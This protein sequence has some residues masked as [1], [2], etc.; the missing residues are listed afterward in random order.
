MRRFTRLFLVTC[1]MLLCSQT[2]WADFKNFSVQVN[3]Q[4]GTL[5]TAAEQTQGT[6]FSFGVAVATDGTV[7]RVETTDASSVA[8]V[9]GKFHSDH[10]ATELSVVVPVDGN[11]KISVGQ[12]TFSGSDIKVTNASGQ[13]V[14]SKSPGKN[15]WK[16]SHDNITELNYTGGATT[17]TISGMGYCPYV[18]VEKSTAVIQKFNV[19]FTNNDSEAVG[20]AP[21]AVAFT[22]GDAP[23]TI[24]ANKT[25]YKEGFTLTAWTDGASKY[26]PGTGFT[27]TADIT[28]TP[29]FEKNEKTLADRTEPVTLLWDFQRKNGAPLLAEEGAGKTGPYVTQ[30]IIDGKSIDVK[31]DYDATNGKIANGNWNDWAQMINGTKF[32][33]PSC[34][35]AVV[36]IEAYSTPTTTTIDGLTD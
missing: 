29:C 7:S 20:K 24:P 9:S 15:C 32:T 26:A 11:V 10:G 17:L 19:T 14:A 1:L 4:A 21:D 8:T 2:S 13:V 25:L 35:G 22:K 23:I 16:N 6:Q 36:S 34:K 12:C 3:N 30:A 27:P 31:M 28:L 33:I 18:A 5:L